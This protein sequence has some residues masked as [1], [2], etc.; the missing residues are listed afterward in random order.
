MVVVRGRIVGGLHEESVWACGGSRM[1]SS[2]YE[3]IVIIG[4]AMFAIV[5]S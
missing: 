2:G 1:M 5:L 4:D 3:L